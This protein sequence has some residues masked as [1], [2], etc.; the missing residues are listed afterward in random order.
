[1]FYVHCAAGF[2]AA[3]FLLLCLLTQEPVCLICILYSQVKRFQAHKG[4]V[5]DL[6]FDETAE[7]VG[8]CSDD[9]GAMVNAHTMPLHT[10]CF[11]CS[12]FLAQHC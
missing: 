8:S 7:F 2:L 4:P 5:N 1:M 11:G 6:C 9:G 10:F 3:A 12:P